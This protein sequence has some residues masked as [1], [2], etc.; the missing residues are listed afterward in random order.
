MG[1]PHAEVPHRLD[2]LQE[3]LSKKEEDIKEHPERILQP[4]DKVIYA[5][6]RIHMDED[7]T[8]FPSIQKIK[9]LS[10]CGQSKVTGAIKRLI[11]AGLIKLEKKLLSNGK[12]S[13]FYIFP[14]TEFDKNFEM[15]TREF[16]ASDL[17]IN[18]K[19]YYMDIQKYMYGKDTGVGKIGYT[20]A[21]L[22][23]LTGISQVSIKKY[24][25]YLIAHNYLEEELTGNYDQAGFPIAKKNFK[26][27][28]F[29]QAALWVRAVTEQIQTNTEDISGLKDNV[30]ELQNELKLAREEI[31]ELKRNQALSHAKEVIYYPENYTL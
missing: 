31:K 12:Y 2:E 4:G 5:C 17:P 9:E 15:Y 22:S 23:E 10:H 1:I 26:L 27:E 24:N 6:I 11:E 30:A 3:R 29:N 20:N 21:K 13:N 28:Q 16:L 25:D 18:I 7:R 19:E 14:K 8:C